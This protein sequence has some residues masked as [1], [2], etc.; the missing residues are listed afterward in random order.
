MK[1]RVFNE[2]NQKPFEEF[3]LPNHKI[4]Y[5]TNFSLL[6]TFE[7]IIKFSE[8]A[9][10]QP[11]FE[12]W[13]MPVA[14][15]NDNILMN[16]ESKLLLK[17]EHSDMLKNSYLNFVREHESFPAYINQNYLIVSKEHSKIIVNELLKIGYLTREVN[18]V[19]ARKITVF[20]VEAR[21]IA[22]FNI[23]YTV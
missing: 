14:N 2:P 18:E 16:L 1:V 19:E 3:T 13:S 10:N 15:D 8:M 23:V 11:Y 22:V 6:M 4:Y 17:A 21:K 7:N 5:F 20:E 12:I 9:V